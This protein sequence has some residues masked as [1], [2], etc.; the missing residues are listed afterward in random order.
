M[1]ALA[2]SCCILFYPVWLWS[3]GS[4]LFS[5]R[6]RRRGVDLGEKES[7]GAGETAGRSEGEA[8]VGMYYMREESIFSQK[9]NVIYGC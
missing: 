6:G 4:L 7:V 1:R 2:L 9:K 5:R 8:M 3:L